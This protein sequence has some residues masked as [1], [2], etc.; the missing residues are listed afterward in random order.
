M[1]DR[2]HQLCEQVDPALV[3]G[4]AIDCPG[5]TNPV[6]GLS[7]DRPPLRSFPR[8]KERIQGSAGQGFAAGQMLVECGSSR[9]NLGPACAMFHPVRFFPVCKEHEERL[10]AQ[11]KQIALEPQIRRA[12]GDGHRLEFS[13]EHRAGSLETG[14]WAVHPRRLRCGA[15]G[16]PPKRKQDPLT[17]VPPGRNSPT[18]G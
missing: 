12:D 7:T 5:L 10:S 1:T 16:T 2:N 18:A 3:D 13:V 4:Q 17:S 8:R 6:I 15:P 14:I 11:V 9:S